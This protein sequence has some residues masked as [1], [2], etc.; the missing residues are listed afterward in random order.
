MGH[1]QL[2]TLKAVTGVA[3]PHA[4]AAAVLTAVQDP[5]LLRLQPLEAGLVFWWEEVGERRKLGPSRG[6]TLT[7]LCKGLACSVP[8]VGPGIVIRLTKKM[9]KQKAVLFKKVILGKGDL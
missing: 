9:Q 2:E 8:G 5:A 6:W 7:L 4:H 1:V 3:L